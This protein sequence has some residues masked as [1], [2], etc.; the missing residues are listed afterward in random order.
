M[1]FKNQ[2]AA[3]PCGSVGEECSLDTFLLSWSLTDFRI[4]SD[5]PRLSVRATVWV[6]PALTVSHFVVRSLRAH[7]Q[8]SRFLSL[9]LSSGSVQIRAGIGR[10]RLALCNPSVLQHTMLV[11]KELAVHFKWNRKCWNSMIK[12]ETKELIPCEPSRF[13]C[14]V[15]HQGRAHSHLQCCCFCQCYCFEWFKQSGSLGSY[16]ACDF[17]TEEMFA[18]PKTK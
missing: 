15:P 8:I 13:V 3:M 6:V 16:E 4:C 11:A 14:P 9:S 12:W 18:I 5:L 1:F 17:I 10:H 2:A 7:F